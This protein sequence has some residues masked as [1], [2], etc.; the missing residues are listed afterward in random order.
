ML[1]KADHLSM[2]LRALLVLCGGIDQYGGRAASMI[3]THRY[4][5]QRI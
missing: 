3:F 4:N 1:F 2:D 5:I